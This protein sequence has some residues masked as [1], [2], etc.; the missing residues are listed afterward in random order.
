MTV[1]WH[2]K[3]AELR[4][5]ATGWRYQTGSRDIVRRSGAAKWTGSVCCRRHCRHRLRHWWRHGHVVL[6]VTSP[7]LA[8]PCGTPRLWALRGRGRAR[9]AG[10][11]GNT[12]GCLQRARRPSSAL[13][14]IGAAF[15]STCW[16]RHWTMTSELC[17]PT[18]ENAETWRTVTTVRS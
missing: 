10:G 17:L 5:A 12:A 4:P 13:A 8:R 11:G 7:R 3:W 15:S 18:Q 6:C 2:V 1:R 14:R 9:A 16:W